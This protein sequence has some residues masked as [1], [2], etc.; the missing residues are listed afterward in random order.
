MS[1]TYTF[2]RLCL[3]LSTLITDAYNEHEEAP[4]KSDDIALHLKAY[5]NN[6]IDSWRDITQF[7]HR[8]RLTADHARKPQG[9]N[10]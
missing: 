10:K 4:W 9:D 7:K 5:L 2:N 1:R 3:N 6:E 8:L